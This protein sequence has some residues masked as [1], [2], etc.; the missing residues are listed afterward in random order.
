MRRFLVLLWA[1]SLGTACLPGDDTVDLLSPVARLEV[2]DVVLDYGEVALGEMVERD[3]ALRNAGETRLA[4]KTSLD[5]ATA[6]FALHAAAG[7]LGPGQNT[8]V[9][10]YFLGTQQGPARTTLVV[11]ADGPTPD[12]GP[13]PVTVLL[14][15]TVS[16][17]AGCEDGNPCTRDVVDPRLPGGCDHV[18]VA[19]PCDDGNA[20][21]RGDTCVLGACAGTAV[22]CD[23]GVAC[24]LDT[25]DPGLGCLALPSA[26]ACTDGD[27]CTQDACDPGAPAGTDGCSHQV[28]TDGTL[29]GLPTCA[30]VPVCVAGACALLP[31]PDGF[32]CDDGN[33]CTVED[34]CQAGA[35]LPGAGGGA[36]PMVLLHEGSPEDPTARREGPLHG[37]WPIS[38]DGVALAPLQVWS[39]VPSPEVVVMWRG[40][41]PGGESCYQNP[42][43]CGASYGSWCNGDDDIQRP[44]VGLYIS[45]VSLSGQVAATLTLDTREV[46][47]RVFPPPPGPVTHDASVNGSVVAASGVAAM[48]GMAGAALVHFPG[49]C[50]AC[51][52][53]DTE[54]DPVVEPGCT[55][56]GHA[57]ATVVAL[58]GTLSLVDVAW[59]GPALHGEP[60]TQEPVR[61]ANGTPLVAAT[62]HPDTAELAVAVVLWN[63]NP[64]DVN[65]D[66]DSE[67]GVS[68]D[69]LEL[70]ARRHRLGATNMMEPAT[71]W[72]REVSVPFHLSPAQDTAQGRLESL[73]LAWREGMLEARWSQRAEG[74]E[75]TPAGGCG[76]LETWPWPQWDAMSLPLEEG[77][78]SPTPQARRHHVQAAGAVE[79]AEGTLDAWWDRTAAGE[80]DA[81]WPAD[82]V[83]VSRGGQTQV[84]LTRTAP[85]QTPLATMQV[86][87]LDGRGA[88]VALDQAG[89]VAVALAPGR[90]VP[91]STT[92]TGFPV[93]TD[94]AL[95]PG[96]PPVVDSRGGMSVLAGL[97][98]VG[99][100]RN[101][102]PSPGLA[103]APLGCG[104]EW[105]PEWGSG[106]D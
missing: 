11:Q 51:L 17:P 40:A 32:P 50:N 65:S 82:T 62:Y 27:P 35:C 58:G 10:V 97:A 91:A 63:P 85:G 45:H 71:S 98:E 73:R 94:V 5:D 95:F 92:T 20:C 16:A 75:A 14:R 1:S 79:D 106:P 76:Y 84:L 3:V 34:S 8:L 86:V 60:T 24:T 54:V 93:D 90:V 59:L 25:C 6:G 47:R 46:H 42:S 31:T 80:D 15:A 68:A 61:A 70:R 72:T 88:V 81:C 69:R 105:N 83:T 56:A 30:Q 66:F 19:G 37:A 100:W 57:L 12:G 49:T 22:T 48:G 4:W 18:P 9:H 102:L 38:V 99:I 101:S 13:A 52:N 53:D 96:H 33:P 2:G 77:A 67:Y 104:P 103:L 7:H 44:S 39:S 74:W 43:W 28:A 21:T 55:P 89:Q 26:A 23:D 64:M 41:G 87:S 36:G 29:C 78:V